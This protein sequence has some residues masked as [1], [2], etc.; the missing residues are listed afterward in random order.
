MHV[1]ILQFDMVHIESFKQRID[2]FVAV[3]DL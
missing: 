3:K 2:K 1:G